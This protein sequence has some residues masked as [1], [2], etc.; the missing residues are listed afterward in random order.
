[1]STR[2]TAL[3]IAKNVTEDTAKPAVKTAVKTNG[4]SSGMLLSAFMLLL[5]VNRGACSLDAPSSAEANIKEWPPMDDRPQLD[6]V[7]RRN[8]DDSVAALIA[9]L[10]SFGYHLT[11]EE[12]LA[13]SRRDKNGNVEATFVLHGFPVN[14]LG[15]HGW[16]R[17]GRL[18]QYARSSGMLRLMR[19]LILDVRLSMRQNSMIISAMQ[20]GSLG[21]LEGG[22]RFVRIDVSPVAARWDACRKKA[23]SKNFASVVAETGTT[24]VHCPHGEPHP[25]RHQKPTMCPV[26]P[27][28]RSEARDGVPAGRRG[29]GARQHRD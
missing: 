25:W 29:A 10:G 14:A 6:A 19:S 5:C 28:R 3:P 21:L 26:R 15:S 9:H 23:H 20:L 4:Q 22:G 18:S 24:A 16:I 11:T 1:M 8:I 2:S 27:V 7:A 13:L 17:A 12:M